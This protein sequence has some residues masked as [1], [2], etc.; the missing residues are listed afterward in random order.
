VRILVEIPR[1]LDAEQKRL[2][3]KLAET[4]L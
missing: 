4:G 2:V 1:H 3:E